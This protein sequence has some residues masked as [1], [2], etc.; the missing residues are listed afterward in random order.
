MTTQLPTVAAPAYRLVSDLVGFIA[1][2]L[3]SVSEISHKSVD[4]CGLKTRDFEIEVEFGKKGGKFT[5]FRRKQITIPASVCSDLVVGDGERALFSIAQ[6]AGDD[7]GDLLESKLLGRFPT[8]VPANDAQIL[9]S[10]NGACPPK[11]D[12]R[13]CDLLDL[14]F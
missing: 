8:G 4:L 7:D 3:L 12:D 9:I 5:E 1:R 14:F 6:P 13:V 11:S 10:D 2:L